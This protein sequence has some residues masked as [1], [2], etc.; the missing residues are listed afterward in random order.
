[1]FQVS[2]VALSLFGWPH[3]AR[4]E[5]ST[6]DL[7]QDVPE[8]RQRSPL[9]CGPAALQSVLQGFGVEVE[10]GKL[11]DL[12][13]VD[14][15][16]GASI[17]TVEDVANR[18]GL[19]AQQVMIPQ[20][21][22]FLPGGHRGPMIVVA[23]A[24]GTLKHFLVLWRV[25]G[26]R[27]QVMDPAS[28]LRTWVDQSELRKRLYVHEMAVPA[29]AWKE[30]SRGPDFRGGLFA[31]MRGVGMPASAIERLWTRASADESLRGMQALDAAVRFVAAGPKRKDVSA[32]VQKIF[33]CSRTTGCS[34]KDR[35]PA[36]FW[37][38]W[39]TGPAADHG[40]PRVTIRGI[41]LLNFYGRS[42]RTP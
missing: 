3:A 12:L 8:V 25:S 19:D 4:L 14:S 29:T 1:V 37:S 41:V 35:A 17:D 31:R 18:L 34:G 7:A 39:E 10:Y 11:V 6:G 5:T 23:T 9:D 15:R 22:L 26:D 36:E 21:H 30:W 40:E 38:A 27:V 2:A 28:G 42:K 24:Q 20:D 33:E 13:E 32:D 16:G